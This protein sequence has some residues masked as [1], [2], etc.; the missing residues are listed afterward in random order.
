MR[1]LLAALYFLFLLLGCGKKNAVPS[2]VL[3]VKQMETVLW[4]MMRADQFVTLYVLPKDTSLKKDAEHKKWHDKVLAI[5]KITEQQ[6]QKSFHYYKEHPKL[7]QQLL[8]TISLSKRYEPAPIGGY[9]KYGPKDTSSSQ[10]KPDTAV[11]IDT[12]PKRIDT[13]KPIRLKMNLKLRPR[14]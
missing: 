6:F 14:Q 11:V 7:L 13:I 12:A 1:Q 10:R 2:D 8:D 9:K 3:P 4:D 5:H